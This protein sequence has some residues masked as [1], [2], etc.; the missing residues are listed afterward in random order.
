MAAVEY[1]KM[2]SRFLVWCHR[3]GSKYERLRSAYTFSWD[4]SHILASLSGQF[5]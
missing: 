5:R 1:N 4:A 2:F 3:D